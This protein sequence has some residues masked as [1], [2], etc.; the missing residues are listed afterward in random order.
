MTAKRR[1][2]ASADIS[3]SDQ[4]VTV[5]HLLADGRIQGWHQAKI[6]RVMLKHF[7]N[8]LEVGAAT[9]HSECNACDQPIVDAYDVAQHQGHIVHRSCRTWPSG[10]AKAI[11]KALKAYQG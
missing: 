7:N 3:A 10:L 2:P 1:I 9:Q 5:D 8:L 4:Y 11:E 6:G